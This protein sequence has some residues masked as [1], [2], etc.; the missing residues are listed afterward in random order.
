MRWFLRIKTEKGRF[1]TPYYGYK[2]KKEAEAQMELHK[3]LPGTLEVE[4]IKG[5]W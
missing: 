3:K 4:V 5:K 1:V 2:T